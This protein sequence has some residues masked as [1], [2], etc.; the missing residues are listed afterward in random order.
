MTVIGGA[1]LIWGRGLV[2]LEGRAK[3]QFPS[4]AEGMS[5]ILCK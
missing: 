1:V 2:G 3:E 5:G 4:V